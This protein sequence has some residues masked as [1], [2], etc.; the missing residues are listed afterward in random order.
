MGTQLAL[1]PRWEFVM[2]RSGDD[3][4]PLRGTLVGLF[5][6][7]TINAVISIASTIFAPQLAAA[8]S[9]VEEYQ[10]ASLALKSP[11]IST[12]PV[13]GTRSELKAGM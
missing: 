12:S 6:F 11:I 9:S 13:V 2:A 5:W 8:A 10:R 7:I 4:G 1:R 3:V